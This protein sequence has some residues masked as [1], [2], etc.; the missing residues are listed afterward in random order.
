MLSAGVDEERP[1]VTP[2]ELKAQ[3]D[4]GE[5]TIWQTPN[6]ALYLRRVEYHGTGEVVLEAG[7]AA[8]NMA[9]I[10]AAIPSLERWAREIG[11]TQVHVHAGRDEWEKA[12]KAHGYAFEKIVLRKVIA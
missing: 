2:E 9:E 7:P 8:G 10:I 11:C 3:V 12:L 5:A 4:R 6:S 1:L